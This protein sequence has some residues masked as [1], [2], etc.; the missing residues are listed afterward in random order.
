MAESTRI[1]FSPTERSL[2]VWDG[3]LL[4]L[5]SKGGAEI[6]PRPGLTDVKVT[7]GFGRGL[8]FSNR[9]GSDIGLEYDKDRKDEVEAFVAT[10]KREV[11]LA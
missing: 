1:E 10:L 3:Y 9:F 2:V 11:G 4:Y 8:H 7:G 6:I 5:F